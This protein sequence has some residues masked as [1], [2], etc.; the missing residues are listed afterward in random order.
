MIIAEID[1][2]TGI[3]AITLIVKGGFGYLTIE[4]VATTAVPV[5]TAMM[6]TTEAIAATEDVRETDK[7]LGFGQEA[8]LVS[9]FIRS[10]NTNQKM[11]SKTV[12]LTESDAQ[13]MMSRLMDGELSKDD[14]DRLHQ[15]L[16]TN[17]GAIG[18]ME[19]SQ[20]MAESTGTSE[21]TDSQSAWEN[22]R[23]AINQDSQHEE[24]SS[25]LIRFPSFFQILGVAAAI[26]LVGSIV[27]TNLPSSQPEITQRYAASQSVVEFV[28]TDIPD[29]SPVVYTDEISGWTVV[30]VA[31]MDPIVDET[32]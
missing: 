23:Q 6:T 1:S 4:A 18:W 7:P 10:L 26:A 31:E 32:G 15:Y 28:D 8:C 24:K 9:E 25:N 5:I 3:P 16:E 20:V 12:D 22:I 13:L 27:W 11:P 19:S 29:A 2:A 30:W 14:A 21:P 17:P